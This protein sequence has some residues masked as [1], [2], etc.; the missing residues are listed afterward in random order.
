MYPIFSPQVMGGVGVRNHA[1][2]AILLSRSIWTTHRSIGMHAKNAALL[3]PRKQLWHFLALPAFPSPRSQNWST[4]PKLTY[5][6]RLRTETINSG[7]YWYTNRTVGVC[8][9][10]APLDLRRGVCPVGLVRQPRGVDITHVPH[11][12]FLKRHSRRQGPGLE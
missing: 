5:E 7:C 8:L 9:G 12:F 2:V 1:W 10:Q 4:P 11:C 3:A 6:N